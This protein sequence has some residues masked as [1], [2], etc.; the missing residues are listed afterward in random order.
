MQRYTNT[1][2]FTTQPKKQRRREW[3]FGIKDVVILACVGLTLSG[4]MGVGTLMIVEW[5]DTLLR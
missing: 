4:L 2:P 5:I 3:R 1:R